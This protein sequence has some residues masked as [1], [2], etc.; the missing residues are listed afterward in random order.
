MNR[1]LY[2]HLYK[3]LAAVA[4]MLAPTAGYAQISCT[5]AGLDAAAEMLVAAQGSGDTSKLPAAQG[6]GYIENFK[7]MPIGEGVLKKALKIDFHRNMVDTTT[8]QTFTEM[9]VT[10]PANPHVI[11]TRL[12]VN[13]DK[14]VEIESL[15]TNTGDWLFNADNY[16]KW[17]PDE[18]WDIIP[19]NKRDS[20]D[21]LVQ[22]GNAYLDAFL[23]QNLDPVPWGEPCNRTEGGMRT[24]KGEPNDSCT[25]GV[26]AGVNITGRHWVVDEAK[27]T[28]TIFCTFGV[29]GLPDSHTFRL[30][31]GKLRYVHTLSAYPDGDPRTPGPNR[32]K[33]KGKGKGKA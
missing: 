20:R 31:N 9:I 3:W 4:V 12:R 8:C 13:K 27:G 21:T 11:G 10:D 15:V 19:E 33:G 2:R 1:N 30:N 24:G 14:I 6:L 25:V 7:L 29:N 26:P 22:A 17:S 5:R 28:I 16:L 32:N 23:E 18:D